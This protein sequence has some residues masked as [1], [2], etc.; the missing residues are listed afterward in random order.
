M[1][2]GASVNVVGIV[3]IRQYPLYI[4]C[5]S[6]LSRSHTVTLS[7]TLSQTHFIT[8]THLNAGD[9]GNEAV[10]MPVVRCSSER[11]VK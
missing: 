5:M 10:V 11:V 8:H 7:H 3:T 9:N 6:V 4:E 2:S 1:V